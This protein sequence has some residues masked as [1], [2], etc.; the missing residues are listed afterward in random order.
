MGWLNFIAVIFCSAGSIWMGYRCNV[1]W[2]L[3]EAAF[4]VVNIPFAVKWIMDG[5]KR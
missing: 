5:F 4:A 2:C 1:G 3:I